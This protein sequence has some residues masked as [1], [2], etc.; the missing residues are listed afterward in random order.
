[1]HLML[2][3]NGTVGTGTETGRVYEAIGRFVCPQCGFVSDI[4]EFAP[5]VVEFGSID[6]WGCNRV[7]K[8]VA[9]FGN[10]NRFIPLNDLGLDMASEQGVQAMEIA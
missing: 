9:R 7:I 4:L 3:I 2:C 8:H 6:C 5:P 10:Q 1:M